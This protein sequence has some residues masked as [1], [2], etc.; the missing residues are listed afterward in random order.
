[1]AATG[2]Y[3]SGSIDLTMT[4][5]KEML[6]LF[7]ELPGRVQKKHAAIAL[8]QGAK[9]ILD[10]AR[11][12]APSETGL[13]KKSIK[14]RR[15]KKKHKGHPALVIIGPTHMKRAYRRMTSG[16][17]AGKLRGVGKKGLAKAAAR[18]DAVQWRDPGNYGHLVE[19]GR[20]ALVA[21][22]KRGKK[23][24]V[25]HEGIIGRRAKAVPPHPFL[26]PAFESGK[27]G[28]LE[29]IRKSLWKGIEMEAR[30]LAKK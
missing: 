13:L 8:M 27:R 11:A 6:R 2:A 4:G 10:A 15:V 30:K 26:R 20:I 9:P 25:G 22:T 5:D 16:K 7:A 23:I 1:M 29:R 19:K 12:N 28:A 17:S 14:A 18:G 3:G 24:M 21:P